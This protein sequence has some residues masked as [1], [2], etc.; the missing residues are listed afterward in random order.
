MDPVLQTGVTVTDMVVNA[1]IIIFPI[2]HVW[3]VSETGD[4]AKKN[5][6]DC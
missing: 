5:G 4:S 6:V 3:D 1:V 2:S